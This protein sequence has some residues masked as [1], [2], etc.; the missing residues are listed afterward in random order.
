MS[1]NAFD[2]LVREENEMSDLK[3]H[4]RMERRNTMS[5]AKHTKGPW[6]VKGDPEHSCCWDSAI[7]TEDEALVAECDTANA[8]LIA[9][10]PELLAA[11]ERILYAH[12]NYGNGA[13]MGE[14][15]LC[16]HYASVARAA[17]AKA[18]GY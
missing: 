8:C 9:A 16:E 12:D 5:N 7:R 10:A 1:R 14:A 6:I 17:I 3:E 2:A 11:L 18:K 15:V 13:A 4:A